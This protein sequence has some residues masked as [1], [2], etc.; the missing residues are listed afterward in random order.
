MKNTTRNNIKNET[1]IV[2]EEFQERESFNITE[3]IDSIRQFFKFVP[4]KEGVIECY[5]FASD[6]SPIEQKIV[7]DSQEYTLKCNLIVEYLFSNSNKIFT[8]EACMC[9][10][11]FNSIQFIHKMKH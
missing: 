8:K 4:V 9:C 1:I 6:P 11:K 3:N 10:P 7:S 5:K 2:I